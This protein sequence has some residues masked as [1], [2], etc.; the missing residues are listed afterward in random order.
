M[1][2][3]KREKSRGYSSIRIFL[4]DTSSD[5][6]FLIHNVVESAAMYSTCHVSIEAVTNC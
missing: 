2:Y 6:F 4:I 1:L 3:E 5:V